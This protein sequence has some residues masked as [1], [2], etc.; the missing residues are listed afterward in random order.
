MDA[1]SFPDKEEVRGSSPRR[2]TQ[3]KALMPGQVPGIWRRGVPP[4]RPA[5]QPA[6]NSDT[7]GGA[8][9]TRQP[10]QKLLS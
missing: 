8:G 6:A 5:W 2:P 7:T 9:K 1:I 4:L 3:V 10:D